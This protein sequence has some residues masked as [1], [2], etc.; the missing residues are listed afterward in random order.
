MAVNQLV[1]N[2]VARVAH[3]YGFEIVDLV[4]KGRTK[5][6]AEARCVAM[7]VA[8]KTTGCSFP[9]IGSALGWRDHTTVMSGCKRV[10]KLLA[11]EAE[12]GCSMLLH[13]VKS[14][15]GMPLRAASVVDDR[16]CSQMTEA[17]FG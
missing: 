14:L 11:D 8:R 7:Y 3:V 10:E 13:T 2:V 9:E 12:R 4:R 16:Q 6:L 15:C 5:K 17:R 1:L